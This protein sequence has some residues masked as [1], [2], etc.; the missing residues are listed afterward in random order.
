MSATGARTWT[1][2]AAAALFL[3]AAVLLGERGT[4]G[5]VR[6]AREKDRDEQ[7]RGLP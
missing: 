1:V 2:G 5:R 3:A 7:L 4:R 6:P